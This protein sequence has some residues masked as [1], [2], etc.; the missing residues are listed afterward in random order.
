MIL[1]YPLLFFVLAASVAA[2]PLPGGLLKSSEVPPSQPPSPEVSTSQHPQSQSSKESPLEVPQPPEPLANASWIVGNYMRGSLPKGL[3]S[4][5]V[6][7][8]VHPILT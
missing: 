5:V 8:F 2:V 7:I 4:S 6:I 1:S 3:V